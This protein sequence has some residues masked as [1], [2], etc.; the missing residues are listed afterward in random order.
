VLF[1]FSKLF[2]YIEKQT[3]LIHK[4]HQSIRSATSDQICFEHQVDARCG[5]HALNNAIQF[6]Y[7]TFEGLQAFAW[8]LDFKQAN[9]EY[10]QLTSRQLNSSASGYFNIDVLVL[11]LRSINCELRH[12]DERLNEKWKNEFSTKVGMFIVNRNENHWY[13][14]RKFN[15]HERGYLFDSMLASPKLIHDIYAEFPL[16]SSNGRI[17]NRYILAEIIIS[18]LD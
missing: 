8:E 16:S 1:G 13:A 12:I 15:Q 18:Q 2:S 5:L 14:I 17:L 6:Q 7:F 11:A 3:R 10:D 9:L 4:L